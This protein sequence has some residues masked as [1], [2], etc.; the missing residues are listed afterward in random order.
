M[1]LFKRRCSDTSPQLVSATPI[2]Q[3]A[4]PAVIENREEDPEPEDEAENAAKPKPDTEIIPEGGNQ[5]PTTLQTSSARKGNGNG[6][7]N[8][9]IKLTLNWMIASYKFPMLHS[10]ISTW[11]R[12]VGR[13]WDQLKRSDSS[14]LLAVSGRRRRHWSPNRETENYEA[15]NADDRRKV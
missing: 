10:G 8:W 12:K 9:E 11:G 15:T 7:G 13:R 1:R 6:N 2:S 3:D 14:E 4:I 5:T